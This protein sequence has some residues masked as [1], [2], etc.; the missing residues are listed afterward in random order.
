MPKIPPFAIQNLQFVCKEREKKK[1]R[2][3]EHV[4]S[5]CKVRESVCVLEAGR[6]EM[7]IK[8]N[9]VLEPANDWL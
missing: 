1:K 5:V 3:R 8:I 4:S 7:H 9:F 2:E 6:G